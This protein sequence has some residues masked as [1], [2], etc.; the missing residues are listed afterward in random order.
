MY[1]YLVQVFL[2]LTVMV[3][4]SVFSQ[5]TKD[6]NNISSSEMTEIINEFTND[7]TANYVYPDIAEEI[8]KKIRSDIEAKLY[9]DVLTAD[10]L[11]RLLQKTAREISHDRHFKVESFRD[12]NGSTTKAPR[13]DPDQ[14]GSDH[15]LPPLFH[16]WWCR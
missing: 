5:E 15:P 16:P 9:A 12:R 4:T 1:S 14:D 13:T 3:G 8:V 6:D 11:A 2:Y 7:I 10:S